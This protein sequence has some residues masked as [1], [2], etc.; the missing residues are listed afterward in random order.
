MRR[1]L[2]LLALATAFAAAWS[3]PARAADPFTV[4]GIHVDASAQSA[5]AAQLAAIAQ[6]R[7]H[8]WAVLYKRIAK[9][10]DIGR[11]PQLDDASL[12]RIIR[13]FVVKNEK[14]STTR[15]VGDVTYVFS[16]EGVARVMQSGGL[17]FALVQTKRILLVPMSPN[18]SQS[19]VWTAAF[20]GSRYAGTAVPFALPGVGD[21]LVLSPLGFETTNWQNLEGVAAKVKA[22]EAVLVQVEPG[23]GH[24]TVNLKRLGASYLP[25]TSSVE[26]PMQPGGAAGTYSSAA[27]AAVH[28]IEDMWKNRPPDMAQGRLTAD[29]RIASLAQWGTMQAEMAAVPNVV[30]VAVQAMDIGEARVVVTYLGNTDQLR[31]ALAGQGITLAKA[32]SDWS[33]SNAGMP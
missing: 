29:V 2:S 5:S 26:V 1:F 21:Q 14:R 27:D 13:S 20:A 12:Q 30:S 3:L 16:P 17:A 28:G 32:G 22:S 19:S 33:L 31:E 6:G 9:P 7:P 15:Y 8:A 10:Q 23:P 25:V 11:Q 18:Y 24:L 4:A